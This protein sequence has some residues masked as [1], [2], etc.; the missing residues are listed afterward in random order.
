MH[1]LLYD[2]MTNISA[3]ELTTKVLPRKRQRHENHCAIAS[4]AT[5]SNTIHTIVS[6]LVNPYHCRSIHYIVLLEL[7]YYMHTL[8]VICLSASI[9]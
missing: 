7:M 2:L 3:S 9:I 6:V 5:S 4:T 8:V 1:E